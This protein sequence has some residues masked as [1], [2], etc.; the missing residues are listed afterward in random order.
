LLARLAS[1]SRD[2]GDCGLVSPKYGAL[3]LRNSSRAGT[4][5]GE[6]EALG[7]ALP[8]APAPAAGLGIGLS[9]TTDI[10]QI[11][12]AA[13]RALF[14]MSHSRA[15]RPLNLGVSTLDTDQHR[16]GE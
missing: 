3:G 7:D 13:S 2:H 10:T 4:G 5:S 6:G 15:R 9:N 14:T 1:S 16:P 8:G 11:V 12:M